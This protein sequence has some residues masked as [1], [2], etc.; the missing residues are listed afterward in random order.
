[1]YL[2]ANSHPDFAFYF[3]QCTIF[4]PKTIPF[5]EE[6]VLVIY[7]Y[8]KVANIN[9]IIFLLTEWFGVDLCGGTTKKQDHVC[10]KSIMGYIIMVAGLPMTCVS[11]LHTKLLFSTLDYEYVALSHSLIYLLSINKLLKELF[12]TFFLNMKIS[13][14]VQSQ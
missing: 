9:G 2:G 14:L 11:K 6:E 8:I 3:C 7:G 12:G 4:T 1:M 13:V 10:V 5:C